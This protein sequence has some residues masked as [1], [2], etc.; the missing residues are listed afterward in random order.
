LCQHIVALLVCPDNPRVIVILRASAV[1]NM[2][3]HVMGYMDRTR[4]MQMQEGGQVRASDHRITG[5]VMQ[6]EVAVTCSKA[7]VAEGRCKWM[8]CWICGLHSVRR[9]NTQV[10]T[11]SALLAHVWS[12]GSYSKEPRSG[13][14]GAQFLSN[15]WY[16]V[17]CVAAISTMLAAGNTA[18]CKHVVVKP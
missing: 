7:P 18:G 2:G 9:G 1:C 15:F 16:G 8:V 14:L 4:T 11:A 3:E 6:G 5:D 12:R 13:W 10:C 17:Q